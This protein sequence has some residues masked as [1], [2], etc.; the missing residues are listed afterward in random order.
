MY[1]AVNT[2]LG[3]AVERERE[4]E[5]ARRARHMKTGLQDVCIYVETER[6]DI[7]LRRS[8]CC[9]ILSDDLSRIPELRIVFRPIEIVVVTLT[10][11]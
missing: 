4:G 10:E 9:S 11:K 7:L 5:T 3:V 8:P 1:E 2:D 6:R